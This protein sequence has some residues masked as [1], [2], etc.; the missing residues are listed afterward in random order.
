MPNFIDI[1]A[2]HSRAIVRAIGER[3]QESFKEEKQLPESFKAQI[4]RLRQSDD[5]AQPRA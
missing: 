5:P 1:D 2:L 3:L 4:E